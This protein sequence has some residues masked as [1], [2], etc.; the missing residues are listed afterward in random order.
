MRK[1]KKI[2]STVFAAV[3]TAACVFSVVGCT[4]DDGRI[5]VKVGMWPDV[6]ARDDVT[7]FKEWEE[8]FERDYPQYDIVADHYEYNPSTIYQKAGSGQLPTIFQAWF[9][10]PQRL[11]EEEVI[12]DI[13]DELKELGWYDQMDVN[14]RAAVSLNDRVY[15][16][17]R[18]GYG[19]GLALNLKMLNDL[20]VIPKDDDGN[21]VLHDEDGTPLYPT[22]F[23]QI[24]EISEL[25]TDTYDTGHFGLVVLSADRNGGWQF[26]NIAWN[27][28][29]SALQ[30]ENEDGSWTAN[31]NDPKAVEALEWIQN[32]RSDG[33]TPPGSS[34]TYNQWYQQ[35]GV[36]NVAM[37]FCGNDNLSLPIVNYPDTFNKDDLA[38]V[39]MP[40][41]E[42]VKASSLYGGT[43]F[44]CDNRASREAIKGALLFLKYM[45]RSPETDEIAV[46]AI[47]RGFETARKKNMPILQTI[48]PWTNKGYVEIM[49]AYEKEYVNV[50][51]DYYSDFFDTIESMK[52]PEEPNF[53]Q[54]MYQLLDEALQGV[55]KDGGSSTDCYNLL[56]TKNSIFQKNYLDQLK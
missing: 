54:D 25:V 19:M 51:L 48:K 1:K 32:M 36:G 11:A 23:D 26:S 12:A 31:L 42:G 14:M 37:A 46:A 49:E 35:L 3:M 52:R 24:R 47:E 17:P 39:P 53:C 22:T 29:C 18:D 13:T 45:G 56:T 41:Q 21:Y 5:K 6:T 43:P 16:V 40:A 15:G 8:N 10:E 38:F 50:N 20:G 27:F 9:T 55:L 4:K 7:M 33:L 30:I 34:L 28:G 2:L 44:V